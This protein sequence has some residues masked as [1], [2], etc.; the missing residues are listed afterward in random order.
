MKGSSSCGKHCGEIRTTAQ[1]DRHWTALWRRCHPIVAESS[2]GVW[3]AVVEWYRSGVS[4]YGHLIYAKGGHQHLCK[5]SHEQ[6]LKDALSLQGRCGGYWGS[7]ERKIHVGGRCRGQLAAAV[8]GGGR[9]RRK[10][11]LNER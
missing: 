10:T 7:G 11:D 6:E 2:R 4:S 1:S 5:K 3:L 9:S 8:K